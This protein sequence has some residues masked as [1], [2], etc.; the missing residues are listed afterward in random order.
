MKTCVTPPYSR[1]K[2]RA[3]RGFPNFHPL[4]FLIGPARAAGRGVSLQA[5]GA[6]GSLQRNFAQ[7]LGLLHHFAILL[8]DDWLQALTERCVTDIENIQPLG[9]GGGDDLRYALSLAETQALPEPYKERL[10]ARIRKV[11]PQVVNRDPA[12]WKGYCIRPLKLV[13]DPNSLVA[14]LLQ[15][16]V[17][18]NLDYLID[19]Q[20]S[21][22]S[23]DP[24]W[25]WGEFYPADWEQARLEWRGR[26][27]LEALRTLNAFGRIST[28]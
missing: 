4:F 2:N 7:I 13:S 1:P 11:A 27:T 22:G 19:E 26:L 14:D 12:E 24:V 5:Q 21:E 20:S 6:R 23:W 16:E 8:P 10:R 17:Q 9:S 28:K 25:D 15:A 3:P 18:L